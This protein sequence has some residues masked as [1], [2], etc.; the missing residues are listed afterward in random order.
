MGLPQLKSP[1]SPEEYL[2][3]EYDAVNKHE[4]YGGEV[5]AMAGGSPDHS[6]LIFNFGG[7]LR[8]A[9]KGRP[10]R[11]YD[12]NLRVRIRDADAYCYPDISVICGER[13]FDPQDANKQTILNPTVIIE[14]LS[15]G[16]EAFDRGGKWSDYARIPS[17]KQFVIVSQNL[18]RVETYLRQEDDKWQYSAV[19]G[20]DAT[21]QLESIQV[22]LKLQE[23][24]DGVES[25]TSGSR[26]TPADE[27]P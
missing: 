3:L 10:C 17:L 1:V 15:P 14:V 19:T 27:A 5:F 8:N 18:P 22:T 4:Y 12:S 11:V 25:L 13:Q 6:L 9:L 7:E 24:Y 2:R 23:I 26:P 21:L 20:L 16:T